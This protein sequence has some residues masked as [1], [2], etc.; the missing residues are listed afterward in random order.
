M[1]LVRDN[2]QSRE[3][4]ILALLDSNPPMAIVLA[5]A[6]LEW[7][8]RRAIIALGT[9]PNVAIRS[10]LGKDNSSGLD[11]YKD[12]WKDE[13]FPRTKERL[14]TVVK[15]W[16]GLKDAFKLRNRLLHGI[17][18]SSKNYA[19]KRLISI[20]QAAKDIRLFCSSYGVNLGARLPIRRRA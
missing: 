19:E 5:A 8:T 13:V 2:S 14:T 10:K 18:S 4:E 12:V 1:F 16:S 7:T 20:I 3:M 6:H 15:D 11:K 17:K 9:S